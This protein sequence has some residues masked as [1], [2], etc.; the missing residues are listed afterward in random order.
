M[1]SYNGGQ[2]LVAA[3]HGHGVDT[4]FGIP[5]THNLTAFA[6][7][8]EYGIRT[9]L[10]RHEQGAGYAADGYARV[11]GRPGVCLTT[12]G[13]AIL[14]AAA[15]AAQAWSDSVPVLFVSPGLPTDHPGLGNGYLHEVRDQRA[16]MGSIVAYSHRVGS[17]AEIPRAVAAAFVAMAGGRPRPVHLEI[18][19][20]LLEAAAPVEPVA[21]VRVATAVAPAAE[22]DAA[23]RL[24]AAAERPVLLVGGGAKAAAGPLRALAE[25]LGAPVLTTANG[26]GVLDEDHPLAVGAGLHQ[27]SARRLAED[28]DVVLAVGTEL[29]PSDLWTGPY[30]LTGTLVRIDIDAA[31]ITTNADPHVRLVGDAADTLDALAKRLVSGIGRSS[32]QYHSQGR[33]R[34]EA[35]RAALR[36][37]AATEGATWQEILAALAPVVDGSTVIAGDSTMVCYYGALS[38]LAVHRPAGFLYPTGGG[39]LGYGLPAAVGAKVAE[40]ASRVIAILGDG[41]IMFTVAELAAAAQL[42]LALPVLVVDNG[43]YGEIRNEMVERGD[44][45]AAVDLGSVDFAALGGSM[46]CRG[47]RIDD[48]ADLTAA[49]TEAFAAD[50]PTVLWLP[51]S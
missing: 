44:P 37:D 42:G 6:A 15:A 3:L 23:A 33:E 14:N 25:R 29:A 11:T 47:V 17:V 19:L 4:V 9:V 38:G 43:G 31:A 45:V 26:K 30:T 34:A 21:P 48:P 39:T 35:A 1:A 32:D 18:P 2:A 24:L 12:S 13:P 50:R 28:A 41:G 7:L 16:A 36:A 22:L 27:P 20:D 49:V 51:A 10:T 8:H 40:P 5:G 46:G